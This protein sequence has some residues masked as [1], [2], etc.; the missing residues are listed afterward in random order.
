MDCAEEAAAARARRPRS[1]QAE[2]NPPRDRKSPV[3]ILAAQGRTRLPELLPLRMQRMRASAFAFLRG[4]AAIMAADLG[5]Q[6]NT[7]LRV[8]LCGDAHLANF[9]SFASP[10]GRPVFDANDFDETLPGPF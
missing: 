10:E 6:E 3:D 8:Q 4:A 9:G 1:H 5:S 2:W 7:G